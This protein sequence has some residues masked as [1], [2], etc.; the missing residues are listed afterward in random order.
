[1]P[2]LNINGKVIEVEDGITLLQ[3]C[4]AGRRRNSAL[5]LSRAPVHR[6]ELPHV[7]RSDRR[8][9]KADGLLR[10][11]RQRSEAEPRRQSSRHQ[12]GHAPGQKGARRRDGVPAHQPPARLPDLRPGR[13][14]RSAGSIHVLRLRREPLQREQARRRRE[15]SRAAH[16]DLHDA[17]HPMHALRPLHDRDR[18]RSAS[19]ARSAAA[20]TWRSAPIWSRGCTRKCRAISSISARSAR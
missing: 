19:L 20:R 1:M 12:Y 17:L 8:H 15:V 10:Y 6:R 13:R 11:E 9:T 7:P 5:L 2:K 18:R 4:E 14:V 16:Q 3:A